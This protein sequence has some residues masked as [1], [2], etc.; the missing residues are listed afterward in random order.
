MLDAD[1]P[2]DA[3][4]MNGLARV[5]FGWGETDAERESFLRGFVDYRGGEGAWS[6]LRDTARAELTRIGWIVHEGA[7]SLVEG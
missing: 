3:E 4:A 5:R 1:V 6:R 7:R 2:A